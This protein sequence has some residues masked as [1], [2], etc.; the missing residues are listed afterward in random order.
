MLMRDLRD[1]PETRPV[2]DG[3]APR[4]KRPWWI[5]GEVERREKVLA[6][7]CAFWWAIGR[8]CGPGYARVRAFRTHGYNPGDHAG[9]MG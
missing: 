1:R 3:R 4:V 7:E 8:A 2:S 9:R 5:A 6:Q